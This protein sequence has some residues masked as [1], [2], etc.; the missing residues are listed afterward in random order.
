MEYELSEEEYDQELVDIFL[1][2]L[3]TD[4][5]FIREQI[6][7]LDTGVDKKN[8]L[9]R[10]SDA[11]GRLA[12][13]ANY[14]EYLSLSAY[15]DAWQQQIAEY[16]VS[17]SDG[18]E[19]DFGGMHDFV[20]EIVRVY[21]QIVEEESQEEESQ[22]ED[23]R[24]DVDDRSDSLERDEIESAADTVSQLLSDQ[25]LQTSEKDGSDVDT[26]QVAAETVEDV[27]DAPEEDNKALFDK[28]SNALDVSINQESD[29]SV[30]SMDS[31]ITE[32]IEAP[33]QDSEK[34]KFTAA[35]KDDEKADDVYSK[36]SQE[37]VVKPDLLDRVATLDAPVNEE[38]EPTVSEPEPEPEPEYAYEEE[39]H[40]EDDD[41]LVEVR[42]TVQADRDEKRK[43][44]EQQRSEP[45]KNVS[46]KM[47]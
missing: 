17:L 6:E 1:K 20:D 25:P 41:E 18:V 28:L 38:E 42:E 5:V 15:C 46:K 32:I 39:T 24:A 12:S 47:P 35:M 26:A 22:E 44:T 34:E 31:V 7:E 19:P 29:M 40:E 33:S 3:K 10:A 27:V 30:D 8:A 36:V 9:G 45:V 11:I 13:S 16:I 2:K 4:I 21:P 14:M 43:L 23:K 37:E